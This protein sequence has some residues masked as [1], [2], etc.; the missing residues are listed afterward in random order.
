MAAQAL[1]LPPVASSLITY[2]FVDDS[3]IP[4]TGLRGTVTHAEFIF[5]QRVKVSWYSVAIDG[6]PDD[7]NTTWTLIPG[8]PR[9]DDSTKT[10]TFDIPPE[11]IRR[12]VG[13]TAF[14]NWAYRAS[15]DEENPEDGFVDS[16]RLVIAVGRLPPPVQVRHSHQLQI[17]P[18]LASTGEVE[19]SW[20]PYASMRI[21][22]TVT[23]QAVR[24]P[25]GNPSNKSYPLTVNA[26]HLGRPLA[27]AVEKSW[28]MIAQ[29]ANYPVD[30]HV[31]VLPVGGAG[32]AVAFT[33]QR[34]AVVESLPGREPAIE[35]P[36]GEQHP[37][38][39][40]LD[41][42]DY[43]DGLEVKVPVASVESLVKQGDTVLIRVVAAD[44]IMSL[45]LPVRADL[46][47]L[48]TGYLGAILP[49]SWLFAHDGE[50][51]VLE[52]Q[53]DRIGASMSGTPLL[54]Q[55]QAARVLTWPNVPAATPE[56]QDGA[57]FK[58]FIEPAKFQAA[59]LRVEV[60]ETFALAPG[61]VLSIHYDGNP[62]G[63]R[64]QTSQP[65][66]ADQP[67]AFLIPPQYLAPNMGGEIKRSPIYYSIGLVSGNTVRSPAYR[68]SVRPLASN[69]LGPIECPQ[70][71][72]GSPLSIRDLISD[73]QGE[74]D[75]IQPPWPLMAVGQRAEMI[76][77][78]VSRRDGTELTYTL[79]DGPTLAPGQIETVL[80]VNFLEQLAL[81]E[82]FYIR[83]RVAFDTVSFILQQSTALQLVA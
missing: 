29:A 1:L 18:G 74:A 69:V 83:T 51:V 63:G 73:H 33:R 52:W 61:E 43:P 14:I 55:I 53:V 42:A 12:A 58:G 34:F 44:T 7:W 17:A 26:E 13:S 75:V 41:P 40:A 24:N 36:V 15:L 46:T 38:A 39:A 49:Q 76:V 10:L 68:L 11:I 35:L 81:N 80:P 56:G 23:L 31:E 60:P 19:V 64:Y 57:D 22:D 66:S 79:F 67:R 9:Y 6:T 78:G 32:E 25:E 62:A 30:F 70:A 28:L 82:Q 50:E 27:W 8:D 45:Y 2:G 3:E 21:G 54:A 72:G 37:G 5:G 16:E 65:I 48:Y 71:P 4:S 59:G 47:T 77:T 20:P